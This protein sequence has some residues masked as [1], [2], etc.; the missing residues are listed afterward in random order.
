MGIFCKATWFSC[1]NIKR[2]EIKLNYKVIYKEALKIRDPT[3]F[4]IRFNMLKFLKNYGFYVFDTFFLIL[5]DFKSI[6]L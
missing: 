6:F 2:P 4:L 5:E 3:K 1:M